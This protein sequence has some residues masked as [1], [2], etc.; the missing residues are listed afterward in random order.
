MAGCL[1]SPFFQH[2]HCNDLYLFDLVCSRTNAASTII[3]LKNVWHMDALWHMTC[4]KTYDQNYL[5]IENL[6][7]YWN[8]FW[9]RK[10]RISLFVF[11]DCWKVAGPCCCGFWNSNVYNIF[12]NLLTAAV[13]CN[14][15]F[16]WATS[17]TNVRRS[18]RF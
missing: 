1:V 16:Q 6:C 11:G 18:S 3:C 4:A 8:W 2:G 13:N 14:K 17:I 10:S 5:L 12:Q 7:H 15:Y 9:N